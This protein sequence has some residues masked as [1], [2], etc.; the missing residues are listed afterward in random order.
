MSIVATIL[1]G[2]VGLRAAFVG[3][4]V[5]GGR[6]GATAAGRNVPGAC[7][8]TAAC[9]SFGQYTSYC[10]LLLSSNA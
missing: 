7:L 3:A 2:L 6:C 9:S 10:E 8:P 5:D 4:I 1:L